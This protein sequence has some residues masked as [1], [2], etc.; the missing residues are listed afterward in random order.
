MGSKGGFSSIPPPAIT[1][2]EFRAPSQ[3]PLNP[4]HHPCAPAALHEHQGCLQG[5]Y[6]PHPHTP[7]C[8]ACL[9]TWHRRS[10]CVLGRFARHVGTRLPYA[11]MSLGFPQ[12]RHQP[13]LHIR[14]ERHQQGGSPQPWVNRTRMAAA[15]FITTE[16]QASRQV[17]T[18]TASPHN[19]WAL[20]TQA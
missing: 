16:L 18:Q 13:K 12:L 4:F 20:R 19:S 6:T 14:W 11:M 1:A 9:R 17:P 10:C 2:P 7:H 3:A 5:Y 8:S 15:R